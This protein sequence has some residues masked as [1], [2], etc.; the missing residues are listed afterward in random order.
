[1]FLIQGNKRVGG[2]E[3]EQ[4]GSTAVTNGA[5][6]PQADAGGV[7]EH[8]TPPARPFIGPLD[9][10][11]AIEQQ[12]RILTS[13]AYTTPPQLYPLDDGRVLLVTEVKPA[14][15]TVGPQ[16]GGRLGRWEPYLKAAGALLAFAVTIA[17]LVLFGFGLVAVVEWGIENAAMIGAG[18]VMLFLG[19]LVFLYA[20]AR[21]RHGHR[22]PRGYH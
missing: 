20:L 5:G 21:A 8:Y 10:H 1:M 11:D 4:E 18:I 15:S 2:D 6:F 16:L 9:V 12:S 7:I 17:V 19:V 22:L 3:Y 13:G 14:T